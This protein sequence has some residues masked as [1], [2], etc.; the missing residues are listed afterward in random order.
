MTW[1]IV[2]DTACVLVSGFM[3]SAFTWGTAS[4]ALGLVPAGIG[5]V[6]GGP[7]TGALG[8]VAALGGCVLQARTEFVCMGGGDWD[9]GVWRR[10]VLGWAGGSTL[11]AVLSVLLVPILVMLT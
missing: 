8:V 4:G 2:A 3:G 7:R 10:F 1:A 9:G 6:V 5:A 11:L